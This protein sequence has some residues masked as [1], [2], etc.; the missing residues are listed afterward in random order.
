M[1]S[2]TASVVAL[3]DKRSDVDRQSLRAQA[4]AELRALSRR[5]QEP[6]AADAH[7][8]LRRTIVLP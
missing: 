1:E 3:H 6:G 7:S 2:R 8:R 4:L 5:D